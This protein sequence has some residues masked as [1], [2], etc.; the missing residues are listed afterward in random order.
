[1]SADLEEMFEALGRQADK[2]PLGGAADARGRGRQRTVTRAAISAAA[3][4]VL[5]LVGVGVALR[6]PHPHAA[7][8]AA[9]PGLPLVG[10]V[11]LGTSNPTDAHT[12]Q[13]G[14]RAYVAWT[15]Y[16]DHTSWVVA[17]GLRSGTPAWAARR[18]IDDPGRTISQVVAVPSAVLVV[19]SPNSGRASGRGLFAFAPDTGVPLWRGSAAADD[20]LA[21]TDQMLVRSSRAGGVV[22]GIDW[23]TGRRA[24]R[25]D[26]R[27][28]RPLRT[29]AVPNPA[30][31]EQI[32]RAGPRPSSADGRVVTVTVGGQV[33]VRQSARG[34][35]IKRTSIPAGSGDTMVAY[36]TILF[37]H[38]EADDDGGPHHIRATDL[39]AGLGSHMIGTVSGEF[40][41]MGSCGPGRVC[42]KTVP[43]SAS[44]GLL[45]AFD[46]YGRR[47]LWQAKSTY[48]GEEISSA[49][50]YTMLS[51]W[52]GSTELFDKDGRQVFTATLVAGWLDAGTL[53]IIAPDGTGRWA[54]WSIADRKLH[55][56]GP[57]P[58][59]TDGFCAST[60][61]VVACPTPDGLRLWRVA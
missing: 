43:G 3:A 27:T 53:L 35:V 54:R 34:D 55:P 13:D 33:E 56:I 24:W 47:K 26:L 38:D 31:E 61:S 2:L 11:D 42:V 22:E 58:Q 19:T 20:S 32:D 45:T 16:E 7:R 14:V 4:V 15:K 48:G 51:S 29:L 39:D 36:D 57:P 41:A 18:P 5:V 60:S 8:P 12:A 17:A 30:D 25:A 44:P 50:G 46:A 49:R 6:D 1:M 9:T 40:V 23:R 28:D 59:E 10:T 52:G 37:S 21:F